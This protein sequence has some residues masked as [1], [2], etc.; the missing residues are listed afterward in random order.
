M[1]DTDADDARMAEEA[2]EYLKRATTLVVDLVRGGHVYSH[3]LLLSGLTAI[4]SI[5]PVPVQRALVLQALSM[6]GTTL[7]REAYPLPEGETDL[8]PQAVDGAHTIG[9]DALLSADGA[10]ITYGGREYRATT[11]NPLPG[12]RSGC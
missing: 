11:D 8:G 3:R 10:T 2:A 12:Y 6:I 5:T 9:P 4:E 7:L 1:N